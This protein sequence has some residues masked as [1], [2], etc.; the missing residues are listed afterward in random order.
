MV[1]YSESIETAV[2]RCCIGSMSIIGVGF[3]EPTPLLDLELFLCCFLGYLLDK[4]SNN[5]KRLEKDIKS[6]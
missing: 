1:L 5:K 4:N 3:Y 6:C 2:L